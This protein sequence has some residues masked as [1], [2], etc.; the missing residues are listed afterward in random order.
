MCS[1]YEADL[2]EIGGTYFCNYDN[3]VYDQ[4]DEEQANECVGFKTRASKYENGEE[5]EEV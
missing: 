4:A 1:N 3:S 2:E 5:I